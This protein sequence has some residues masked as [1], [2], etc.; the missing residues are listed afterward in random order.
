LNPLS[1]VAFLV[2]IIGKLH[3]KP[4]DV[5]EAEVE[6]VAGP[7]TEYG[8][9]LLAIIEIVKTFL[10]AICVGLFIALFLAGGSVPGYEKLFSIPT[11][12]LEGL[13]IVL[14]M[15]LIHTLNPRFR[16]DQALIWYVR[17]PTILAISGLVWAYAFRHFFPAFI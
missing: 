8:G 9:R 14:V 13:L 2:A 10:I 6:I 16:I 5:P 11:F 4:F 15:T 7:A 3:L 1:A 17:V 12:L